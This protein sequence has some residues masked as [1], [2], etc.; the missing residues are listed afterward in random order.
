MPSPPQLDL[1]QDVNRLDLTISE[2]RGQIVSSPDKL[3]ASIKELQFQL[4]RE[5][6][7]LR[8]HEAKERQTTN[9]IN[10]LGQ[11]SLVRPLPV[12]PLRTA[13]LTSVLLVVLPRRNC[14]PASASSTTGK[15]T[16]TNFGKRNS[17]STNTSSTTTLSK[18]SCT[19]LRTAS[20]CVAVPFPP[21]STPA[22][23][24]TPS[25]LLDRR[26]TNGRDELVRMKEKMERRREQA[27][28]RKKGLEDAHASH[29]ETKKQLE[30]KAAEKNRQAL[31]VEQQVRSPFLSLPFSP[32]G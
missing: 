23:L 27:K 28:Q 3:Q 26:I 22:D 29:F 19:S 11:Y 2:L 13:R 32:R 1:S 6:E 7:M 12:L 9:K 8:D 15:R 10:L 21:L 25:Q 16:P 5:T 24:D 31:E 18:A 17:S 30:M 20:L 14:T 4:Q